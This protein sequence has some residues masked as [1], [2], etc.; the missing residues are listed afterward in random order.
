M[1]VVILAVA[2]QKGSVGKILDIVI[3]QVD[4]KRLVFGHEI[5]EALGSIC[6]SRVFGNRIS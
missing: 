3:N 4:G 2:N 1:G 6:E 5:E